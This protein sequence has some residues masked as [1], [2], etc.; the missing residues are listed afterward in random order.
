MIKKGETIFQG[1][2]F[3]ITSDEDYAGIEDLR[4]L[5]A[6][7]GLTMR[8]IGAELGVNAST[9]CRWLHGETAPHPVL[10]RVFPSLIQD[11]DRLYPDVPESSGPAS[12]GLSRLAALT[13]KYDGDADLWAEAL[14]GLELMPL[15]LYNAVLSSNA[16]RPEILDFLKGFGEIARRSNQICDVLEKGAK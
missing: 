10:M 6:R 14:D 9:I 11:L 7:K 1:V 8:K 2:D 5:I 16:P 3:A 4:A 12:V 13:N 15:S